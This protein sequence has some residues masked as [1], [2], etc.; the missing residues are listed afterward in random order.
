MHRNA[1]ARSSRNHPELDPYFWDM[2]ERGKRKR[3]KDTR[4]REFV[5]VLCGAFSNETPER[6]VKER[7]ETGARRPMAIRNWENDL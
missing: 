7:G 1:L 4:A 6:E 5:R 2:Q 3:L